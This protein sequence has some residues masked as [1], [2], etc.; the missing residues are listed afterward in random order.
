LL[1]YGSDR[2]G[3]AS[4]A[5][6]GRPL[7]RCFGRF[8]GALIVAASCISAAGA[9]VPTA[10]APSLR[11]APVAGI[12]A[13]LVALARRQQA[14][15]PGALPP[16][17][18]N[19]YSDSYRGWP[20]AP[21]HR[22][23]PIRG[24]FLDPRGQDENGLAGY[25]FGIDVNVDDRHPERGAPPGLSH[26]VYAVGGGLAAGVRGSPHTCPNR[27]IDVGHFAY[28]HV[29]PVVAAGTRIKPGQLIGW[30]CLGEW[31]VHLSEWR[32]VGGR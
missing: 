12:V 9:S 15:I 28:W 7:N 14:R 10:V 3:T 31:H 19:N 25:H 16:G 29:S 13:S 26:R 21:L 18:R 4:A 27:R 24:S 2:D 17:Y 11:P 6:E 5:C 32:P 30:T 23:H 22:Q 20:V 8:A 1:L